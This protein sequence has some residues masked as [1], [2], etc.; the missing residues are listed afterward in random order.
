M[1]RY[2]YGGVSDQGYNRETNEDYITMVELDKDVLFAVVADG[3]GS[4]GTNTQPAAIVTNEL[5]SLV[6]DAYKADKDFFLENASY[7]L[8]TFML[9]S[10]RV[11]GA[12][13]MGNEELYSG[14]SA[15]VTCALFDAIGHLTFAH[16]GNT[17]LYL[18]RM[19]KDGDLPP[20]IQL[21]TDHTVAMLQVQN[22]EM[23]PMQYYVHPDRLSLYSGIGMLLS[24]DIQ[25]FEL[26]LV[27]GDIILMSTDGIHFAVRQKPM[28]NLILEANDCESAVRTLISGAKETKYMDNMSAIMVF[29][30]ET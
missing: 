22:G 7:L 1:P 6:R 25:T 26:D 20:L 27:K 21:T 3:A 19:K 10:N 15:S 29:D 12:F 16:A 5:V 11:L 23:E 18:M 24:P 9:C 14:Y 30:V 17:R 13:K 2:D 8:N 4:K 28:R